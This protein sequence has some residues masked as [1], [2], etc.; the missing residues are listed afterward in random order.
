MHPLGNWNVPVEVVG[1]TQ[2][3]QRPVLIHQVN[4][5]YTKTLGIPLLQG[6]L[7]TNSEVVGKQ[8]LA[9]V[10]RTFVRRYLEQREALGR[11]VRIPR[12]RSAP[13]NAANDSFEIVGV[14]KDTANRALATEVLPEIY[15]PFT[16]TGMA[17]RLVVLSGTAP[18]TVTN[19]VRRQVYAIDAEQPL[20]DVRTIDAILDEWV[21]AEPRFN[22][23]LFSVFAGLG[24]ALAV[25][26]VY[27]VMSHSVSQ[28]TQEIGVRIALGAGFGEIV[29]MVAMG[30]LKLLAVGIALGLAGG[31]ATARL[32]KGQL[33]NVSPF[34]PLSFTLVSAVL[35]VAGIQACLWPA[36]RA[37]RIDP[38][39]ALR[40]E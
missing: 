14:V 2:Q 9:L 27:G 32:L 35:L 28:R 4:E 8:R 1:N 39:V 40:F 5:D 33:W 36:F 23:A 12:L 22:L 11:I 26:G 7:F 25:V 15:L 10:N 37:A 30:G 17:D 19:G 21:F 29:G 34:D 31:L 18:A 38:V 3:D 20:T 13:F 24:L 6:R 16:I